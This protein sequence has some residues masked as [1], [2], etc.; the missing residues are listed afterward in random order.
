MGLLTRILRTRVVLRP[1]PRVPR[2]QPTASGNIPA[3]FFRA[4]VAPAI[5]QRVLPIWF[6]VGAA[7][8]ISPT[9][10]HGVARRE[11][12]PPATGVRPGLR[13]PAALFLGTPRI[14]A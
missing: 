1:R 14:W 3:R 9:G 12:G 4:C 8:I 13:S 10:T 2:R 6:R 5:R 11:M 7:Q